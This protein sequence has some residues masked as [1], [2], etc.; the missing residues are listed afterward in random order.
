MRRI[1]PGLRR[2]TAAGALSQPV[3][4]AELDR[5]ATAVGLSNAQLR[6]LMYELSRP[7]AQAP[8][9]SRT[10][11]PSPLT[12]RETEI[13]RK[14]AEG[15]LY[16]DIAHATGVSVSTVRSHPLNVYNKLGVADRAQAVLTATARGWI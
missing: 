7:E 1:T 15:L 14:L 5:A 2:L 3:S 11:D 8:R 13:L 6:T 12:K 16:K 10:L 4:P 9:S